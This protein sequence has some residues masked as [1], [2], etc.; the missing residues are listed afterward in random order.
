ML[1]A[2]TLAVDL[3]VAEKISSVLIGTAR[4]TT[5]P[6]RPPC[7]SQASI[8]QSRSAFIAP[9]GCGIDAVFFCTQEKFTVSFSHRVALNFNAA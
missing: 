2:G 5:H 1:R 7:C 3:P 4:N 9:E 8:S 6:R